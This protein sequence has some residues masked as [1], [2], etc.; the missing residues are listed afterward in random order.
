MFFLTQLDPSLYIQLHQTTNQPVFPS[1]PQVVSG[2]SSFGQ[3]ATTFLNVL[4]SNFEQI[5]Q[6]E[7]TAA[8][9]LES[10]DGTPKGEVEDATES[11]TTVPS[12]VEGGSGERPET[13]AGAD[14]VEEGDGPRGGA[15]PRDEGAPGGGRGGGP[16]KAARKG[17]KAPPIRLGVT[18]LTTNSSSAPASATTHSH[19]GQ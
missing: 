16:K 18:R 19:S 5:F 4:D 3:K 12:A 11:G 9:V 7:L 2:I 13:F 14:G 10:D 8:T 17:G 6:Q 1:S 15:A